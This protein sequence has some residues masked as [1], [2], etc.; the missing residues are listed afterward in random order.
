MRSVALLAALA[1]TP[2]AATGWLAP[3]GHLVDGGPQAIVVHPVAGGSSAG[4]FCAAGSYAM[5]RLGAQPAD[6]VVVTSPRSGRIF[7]PGGETVGFRL[8]PGASPDHGLLLKVSRQ[9]EAVSVAHARAL[10]KEHRG[11]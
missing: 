6:A 2:A 9:G 5:E 7:G 3:N 1:A 4:I 10:C 8:D 11:H